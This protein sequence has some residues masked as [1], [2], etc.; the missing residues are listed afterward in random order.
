MDLGLTG[1][2]QTFERS[3]LVD[4]SL[5]FGSSAIRLLFARDAERSPVYIYVGSF[6]KEAWA[7][8]FTAAA[9]FAVLLAS[10]ALIRYTERQ[11]L[12]TILDWSDMHVG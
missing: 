9:T 5:P 8:I 10:L 3:K 11:V 1:F 12:I 7:G 4:F 6:L 2:S